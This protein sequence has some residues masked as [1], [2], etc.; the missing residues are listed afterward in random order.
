VLSLTGRFAR[1]G[2]QAGQGLRAWAELNP[3]VE[4]LVEDDSGAVDKVRT[5]VRDLVQ[6]CDILLGPYS[7]VLARAAGETAAESGALLWNHGGSGDDVQD[8]HQGHVLSVLTPTSSY[9]ESF[10]EYLAGLDEVAPLVLVQGKGSFGQQVIAG[11]EET[12]RRLGVTALHRDS[13]SPPPSG[14]WDLFTAGTFE[15]DVEVVAAVSRSDSAPRTIGSVAAGVQEFADVVEA[16]ED[17][18]GVAQWSRGLEST[19]HVGPSEEEFAVAYGRHGAAALDYPAVQ[20]A[21][22]AALAVQCVDRAGTTAP[23]DVFEAAVTLQTST[24]FGDFAVDA[25]SGRQL[26]HRMTLV[27]W[28]EGALHTFH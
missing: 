24:L 23:R 8:A 20:I 26:A 22:A 17:V 7:T 16:T 28:A 9:A 1:F 13:G 19:A 11:A 2:E 21:A 6:R 25:R 4:L 12:A 14:P 27:R 5:G 10:V 15:H 18:F 3:G